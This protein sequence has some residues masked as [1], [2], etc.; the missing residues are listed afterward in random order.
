MSRAK[1]VTL[2]EELLQVNWKKR[3]FVGRKKFRSSEGEATLE[4]DG[5]R[6]RLE[7]G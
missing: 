4:R 5:K 3:I 1:V 6:C 7:A 2:K